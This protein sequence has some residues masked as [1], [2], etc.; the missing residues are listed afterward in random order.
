MEHQLQ[1]SSTSLPTPFILNH[2]DHKRP[3]FHYLLSKGWKEFVRPQLSHKLRSSAM[4]YLAEIQ[5]F[6]LPVL[7][8]LAVGAAVRSTSSFHLLGFWGRLIVDR[9]ER[10]THRHTRPASG[11]HLSPHFWAA[12]MY[13]LHSNP[14]RSTIA[15]WCCMR[16][17]FPRAEPWTVPSDLAA[18]IMRCT[19]GF[20][21]R[22]EP[23]PVSVVPSP[24]SMM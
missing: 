16:L 9:A 18:G 2:L 6:L 20:Q 10:D 21:D 5:H 1:S 7:N 15:Y 3:L 13:C 24:R 22:A 23:C 12:L 19:V 11:S 14:C 4:T 8:K 17:H